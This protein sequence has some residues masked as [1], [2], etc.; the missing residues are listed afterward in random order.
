MGLGSVP[1]ISKPGPGKMLWVALAVLLVG[2]VALTV[3]MLLPSSGSIVVAVSGPGNRAVD[4]VQVFVDGKKYCDT[5][6][7]VANDIPAGTHFVKVQATGYANPSAQAVKVQRGDEAV[8]NLTLS[9]ASEGTGIKVSADGAAVK[10]FVDGKEVGPLP[11]EIKDLT[12][13]EHTIKLDSNGRFETY[14]EKVT[15]VADQMKVIGPLKLKVLRG[16][17]NIEAGSNAD[18]V[19]VLLVTGSEK[20]QIPKLPYK[21]EIDTSKGY[22]IVASKKGYSTVTLP[23]KFE[24]GKDQQQ[25]TINLRKDGDDA[26]ASGSEPS[27]DTKGD[28]TPSAESVPTVAHSAPASGSGGDPRKARL[29]APTP[30][31]THTS[32]PSTPAASKTTSGASAAGQGTLNINSI[33]QSN[34]L[35]DG[36]PL[37]KTPKAGVSVSGGSH[38]VVFIHPEHGRKQVV[39]TVIPGRAATAAVRFP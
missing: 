24:D 8:L 22:Q 10:L 6:P 20:R 37:G 33:P 11:Q 15:V 13:G 18:G 25:F 19:K 1:A 29:A 21:V 28:S 3:V 32:T 39:V 12:P 26:V 31:A 9:A 30:P 2:V 17:V 4:S 34:V 7:C 5:S 14:E 23:V 35:L 36:R 16:T 38:T 27:T